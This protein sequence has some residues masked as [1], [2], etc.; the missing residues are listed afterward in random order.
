[1]SSINTQKNKNGKLVYRLRFKVDGEI[2]RVSLGSKLTQKSERKMLHLVDRLEA[3]HASGTALDAHLKAEVHSLGDDLQKK[4]IATGLVIVDFVPSLKTFLIDYISRKKDVEEHT[5]YKL[6]NTKRLFL[7]FF[8]DIELDQITAGDVEDYIE[9]RKSDGRATATVAAE[10]KH[11]KQFFGYAVRKKLLTENPFEG[12]K[13][14]TQADKKRNEILDAENVRSVIDSLPTLEWR[15][16][17]SLIRWTGCR[18]SEALLLRWADILWD[19]NRIIMP[20]PKTAKQGKP[21]REIPLFPELLPVLLEWSENSPDGAEY[22]ISSL[23]DSSNRSG[24]QGKNLRKPFQKFISLAGFE[25]WPKPF[26]NLR[27]TRENEL[28]RKFPSH[29]V[30]AWIGHSRKTAEAH[31]L[32]LCDADF[33]LAL[34][35]WSD[36]GQQRPADACIPSPEKLSALKKPLMQVA[37]EFCRTNRRGLAP[38]VGLEPTT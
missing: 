18:A 35:G 38:R 20:A 3:H 24:R 21:T 7:V 17:V 27:I 9:Q 32:E 31:Y 16:Y 28:E 6:N 19:Q 37:A 1:M 12:F 10:I 11:G 4:L 36:N 25:P 2:R 22:V 34:Q 14:G 13:V 29:V 26:Q 15:A 30:Q 33:D 8:G 23:V 5:L